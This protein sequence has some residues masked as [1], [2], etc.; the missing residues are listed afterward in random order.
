MSCDYRKLRDPTTV[1]AISRYE[2]DIIPTTING[3]DGWTPIWTSRNACNNEVRPIIGKGP[4]ELQ[5]GICPS[6]ACDQRYVW[7][8]S[9]ITGMN[10]KKIRVNFLRGRKFFEISR[11]FFQIP[12]TI[13][14]LVRSNIA[15]NETKCPNHR[16]RTPADFVFQSILQALSVNIL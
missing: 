16:V 3:H 7:N 12:I 4:T 11:I 5:S 8:L 2:T 6:K 1:S 10:G 14:E 13:S 15:R 9:L